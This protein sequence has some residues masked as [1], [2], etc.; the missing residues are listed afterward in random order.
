MRHFA[1]GSLDSMM[2]NKAS[3]PK[4]RVLIIADSASPSFGGQSLVPFNIFKYLRSRGEEVWLLVHER[5]RGELE[6]LLPSEKNR[7][8][9]IKDTWFN[10]AVHRLRFLMPRRAYDFSLRFLSLMEAEVRARHRA[11]GLVQELGI[12]LI[13][14]VG[15]VSPR[16]VSAIF[17]MS[18]P[19]VV[20]PMNGNMKFPPAFRALDGVLVRAFYGAFR[21]VSAA[22]HFL[23]PGKL[24]AK[25]LLVANQRTADA[26]PPHIRGRVIDF[27]ENGV[28]HGNLQRSKTYDRDSAQVTIGYVGRLVDFKSVDILIEAFAVAAGKSRDI[29][30]RLLIV[31]DGPLRTQLE[32]LA[33]NLGLQN[34]TSFTGWLS[35]A[36]VA[37]KLHSEIDVM[38]FPSVGDCGGAAVL[39]A[40]A[41]GLP[42]VA[43]DWG[44]PSDY[45]IPGSGVLLPPN[46]REELIGGF[47]RA[48]TDLSASAE[49]RK[50]LGS[51]AKERAREFD[52]SLKVGN[53]VDIY[54]DVLN[55]HAGNRKNAE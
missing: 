37:H 30:L 26:L 40:M 21:K 49:L 34:R 43:T 2:E 14:H 11:L 15:P 17:G 54:R 29:D 10:K 48:L 16:I 42:V 36:D 1:V 5:S 7:I 38:A 19:V 39:E 44:G 46:S 53:L 35:Q 8:F 51:R 28:D 25:V 33:K 24:R 32:E 9:Y 12:E 20:G 6:A 55:S 22:V 3:D 31:G 41:L 45:I 50:N 27:V 4:V 18:V 23:V 47:A 13:H 52:W